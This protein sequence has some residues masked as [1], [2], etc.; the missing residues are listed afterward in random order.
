M[1]DRQFKTQQQNFPAQSFQTALNKRHGKFKDDLRKQKISKLFIGQL[2]HLSI[3]NLFESNFTNLA[4]KI[5]DNTDYIRSVA[6]MRRILSTEEINTEV[7]ANLVSEKLISSLLDISFNLKNNSI[8]LD[9]ILTLNNIAYYLSNH[10]SFNILSQIIVLKVF[11]IAFFIDNQNCT[12]G[13]KN[14]LNEAVIMLIG[15]LLKN[16]LENCEKFIQ[17]NL[18][19]IFVNQLNANS[20]SLKKNVFWLLNSL[21]YNLD[22]TPLFEQLLMML[23]KTDLVGYLID[24][25]NKIGSHNLDDTDEYITLLIF[26]TRLRTIDF[27]YLFSSAPINKDLKNTF[28]VRLGSIVNNTRLSAKAAEL[29]ANF[30]WF[31]I[32]QRRPNEVLNTVLFEHNVA[33]DIIHITSLRYSANTKYFLFFIKNLLVYVNGNESVVSDAMSICPF[34]LTVKL[35]LKENS[36]ADQLFITGTVLSIL[37]MFHCFR[38]ENSPHT[39]S[40]LKATKV[41]ALLVAE[42]PVN[43]WFSTQYKNDFVFSFVFLLELHN[44]SMD[45][46]DLLAFN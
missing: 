42:T 10:I 28:L 31:A 19:F 18:L 8:Q 46:T 45:F 37:N 1:D 9:A 39:Q 29:L 5:F 38:K 4:N 26:L 30:L 12:P 22:N 3:N 44:I 13:A 25:G 23:Q 35:N 24:F 16:R 33:K 7:L 32:E 27:V 40:F 41:F 43:I 15:N 11:E 6:E 14:S 2:E 20:R 34:L 36:E 21:F 17:T